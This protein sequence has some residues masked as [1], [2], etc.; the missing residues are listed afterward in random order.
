MKF[1]NQGRE[2]VAVLQIEGVVEA[3]QVGGHGGNEIVAV[4]ALVRFAH[5]QTGDFCDGVGLIRRLEFAG[6]KIVFLDRLRRHFRIDTRRS[7]KEQL[8]YAVRM[9]CV[10]HIILYRQ[11]LKYEFTAIHIVGVNTAHARRRQKYI[12]RP[13]GLEKLLDIRLT[14]E[15]EFA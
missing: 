3:V 2:D 4:L 9:R 7:E 13:L 14:R 5:F 10:Y 1:L 6:E 8:F 12:F 15:I 11:V